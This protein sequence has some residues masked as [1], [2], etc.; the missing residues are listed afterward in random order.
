MDECWVEYG[1]AFHGK[2]PC[3]ATG[4]AGKAGVNCGLATPGPTGMNC[5]ADGDN[6]VAKCVVE[7]MKKNTAGRP[8]VT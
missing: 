6:E 5:G 1:T 7:Y 3:D 8:C 2:G 4:A